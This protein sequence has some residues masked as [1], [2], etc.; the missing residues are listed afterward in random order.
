MELYR[1]MLKLRM[2]TD[3]KQTLTPNKLFNWLTIPFTPCS[4]SKFDI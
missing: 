4:S 3:V 2:Q 1:T